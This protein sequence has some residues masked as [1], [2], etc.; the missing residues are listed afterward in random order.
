MNLLDELLLVATNI[1][2]RIHFSKII[3]GIALNEGKAATIQF[4]CKTSLEETFII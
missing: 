3:N 2:K 4:C 1:K